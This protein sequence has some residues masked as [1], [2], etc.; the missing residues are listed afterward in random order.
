M[1]TVRDES[2]PAKVHFVEPND[3]WEL[4]HKVSSW[5][6]LI[7]T[8]ARVKRY[9]QNS[10]NKIASR[11]VNTSKLTAEEIREAS[12]FWLRFVQKS[13]FSTEYRTLE[14]GSTVQKS[15]RLRTLNP[16]IGK[17]KLIRVGGRLEN[18]VL[19]YNEQHPIILPQHRVSELLIEQAHKLVLHGGT[20]LMLRV[21]RQNYWII[22]ARKLVKAHVHR[23]VTY[24]RQSANSFQQLMGQL[25]RDRV[26]QAPPFTHTGVDYAGPMNLTV[27]VG[28]GQK[29]CKHYVAVFVCLV[30]KAIYL[31]CVDDYT[32]NVSSS[33]SPLRREE[34]FAVRYL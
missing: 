17:D 28:R 5:L 14:V 31:E 25:S 32:T 7:R 23:C 26:N 6:R 3:E 11:S 21:L 20:Q 18:S 2:R 34:R 12:V 1:Q 33:F 19:S 16:F 10:R 24:A 22:L 27:Y 9:I 30:T 15:N 29:T 4:P 8:T 13:Q